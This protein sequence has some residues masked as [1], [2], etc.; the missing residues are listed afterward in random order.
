MADFKNHRVQKYTSDG[1]LHKMGVGGIDLLEDSQ[2]DQPSAGRPG[3]A[4][5]NLISIEQFGG[6]VIR[7]PVPRRARHFGMRLFVRFER[8]GETDDCQPLLVFAND[9]AVFDLITEKLVPA[10][11]DIGEARPVGS[12]GCE[13]L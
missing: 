8:I 1:E 12:P 5:E 4:I 3:Q 10:T 7:H 9:G 13:G 2:V 6:R 11:E